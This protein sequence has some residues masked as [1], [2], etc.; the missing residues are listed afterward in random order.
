[1]DM[2]TSYVLQFDSYHNNCH[3]AFQQ[4]SCYK[5]KAAILFSRPILHL[6]FYE[7]H[8]HLYPD[9]NLYRLKPLYEELHN[10]RKYL[11]VFY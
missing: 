2:P 8:L 10:F 7:F 3:P 4:L 6:K 9:L 1:M 11:F 5:T